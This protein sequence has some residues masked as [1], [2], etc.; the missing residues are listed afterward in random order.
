MAMER[1]ILENLQRWKWYE[2][3]DLNY[4]CKNYAKMQAR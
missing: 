4:V 3:K 2:M 1:A